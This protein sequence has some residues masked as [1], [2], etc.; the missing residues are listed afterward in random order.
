MALNRWAHLSE[1]IE[2]IQLKSLRK[3]KETL[4][5]ALDEARKAATSTEKIQSITDLLKEVDQL[6]IQRTNMLKKA[7][8]YQ[9]E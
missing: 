1:S 5:I 7:G 8:K 3:Q 4:E 2:M 6:I 9:E